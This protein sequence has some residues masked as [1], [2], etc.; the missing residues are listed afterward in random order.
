MTTTTTTDTLTTTILAGAYTSAR[1][2]LERAAELLD[3]TPAREIARSAAQICRDLATESI[4]DRPECDV[5]ACTRAARS[6]ASL[7]VKTHAAAVAPLVELE[8]W[9][10]VAALAE[11]LAELE[12]AVVQLLAVEPRVEGRRSY[13]VNSKRAAVVVAEVLVAQAGELEDDEGEL[14]RRAKP[15][16]T[17]DEV[18]KVE[19]RLEANTAKALD[20]LAADLEGTDLDEV[21]GRGPRLGAEH[22]KA[23]DE[24]IDELEGDDGE[25]VGTDDE[26]ELNAAAYADGA[27]EALRA[28]R[29]EA[30]EAN[31]LSATEPTGFA[32]EAEYDEAIDWLELAAQA[33]RLFVFAFGSWYACTPV[34]RKKT[35]ALVVSYTSG[36]GVTRDKTIKIGT[37]QA[38]KVFDGLHL[39]PRP[40]H[41]RARAR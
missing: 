16:H 3:A 8:A 39:G 17:A 27:A 34:R 37:D 4:K 19:A 30:I 18:A 36:T 13:R 1:R 11:A 12:G 23:D 22:R 7:L 26:D 35:G 40:V 21:L 9:A 32:L 24:L 6:D 29:L 33:G 2:H 31:T 25:Y 5:E 10:E 38:G 28:Q 15:R 41:T 20:D 14:G